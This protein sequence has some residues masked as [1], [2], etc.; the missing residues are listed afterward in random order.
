MSAESLSDVFGGALP[1]DV[2]FWSGAGISIDAPTQS[3]DGARLTERVLKQV[4][5]PQLL[6]E[7]RTAYAELD[8]VRSYPRLETILEIVAREHGLEILL[9][10]L[11]DI[12]EAPPNGSHQFFA[13][14]TTLGGVH[15]TA[16]FDT[17]IERAGGNTKRIVHFHGSLQNG[18]DLSS[19]GL[20]LSRVDPGF[21]PDLTEQ[22]NEA[23]NK[24]RI[25]VMVG[26]GG[27]DY[28]DVDPYWVHLSERGWFE[29]KTLLWI[30]HQE[31]Q[32][33][34]NG[35]GVGEDR[36]LN[37]LI[38]GQHCTGYELKGPTRRALNFL[39]ELWGMNP[40]LNP[41]TH[42]DREE[43][44]LSLSVGAREHATTRFFVFA[45]LHDKARNRLKGKALT[46]EEHAWAADLAWTAGQYRECAR[47]WDIVFAGDDPNSRASREERLAATMWLRGQC[48]LAFRRLS[49]EIDLAME[50]REV[51]AE[52]ILVM[53]ETLGRIFVSMRRLPDYRILATK[54]R[55]NK[56]LSFLDRAE[57]RHNNPI[58]IELR[59]RVNSMRESVTRDY[60][61]RERRSP[62]EDFSQSERLI[63]MLNYKH[64]Q[65]RRRVEGGGLPPTRDECLAL[66]HG[67]RAL[68]DYADAA[69]TPLLPKSSS[70]FTTRE[71]W[72]GFAELDFTAWHRCRLFIGCQLRRLR[73]RSDRNQ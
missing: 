52:T 35:G 70:Y 66:S 43:Q 3:P 11:S 10:L 44:S 47:H 39:A 15:V 40:I 42:V 27:I 71:I 23:L 5:V 51:P 37:G 30:D 64:S 24:A 18:G 21:D 55:R 45:G 19:L 6:K 50:S 33:S 29:D 26:Y 2:V 36:F 68:G 60:Q 25:L 46:P 32:W 58:G 12:A 8:V 38:S 48:R 62:V 67:F 20:R 4:F 1:K 59:N 28:F 9:S 41:P 17:C 16:N 13:E 61:P 57:A 14:H 7:L 49:K 72:C 56:V 31:S 63:G 65:I 22:L 73:M 34:L 69:R 53:A 54:L